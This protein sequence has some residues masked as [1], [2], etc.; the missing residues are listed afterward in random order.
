MPTYPLG[1]GSRIASPIDDQPII[2]TESQKE[3]R[4]KKSALDPKQN[5]QQPALNGENDERYDLVRAALEKAEEIYPS[6]D[7]E[8]Q[9]TE[10]ELKGAQANG[11]SHRAIDPIVPLGHKNGTYH[12]ISPSG[13]LRSMK[14]EGLEAGRGVKALF[15]G[16]SEEI[17]NWCQENFSGPNGDWSQKDA[18]H[19]IIKACNNRGIFDPAT[20][21]MRS[22]GVWRDDNTNAIAH[23]GD[24][25]VSAGG[26][27]IPLAEHNA[28]YIA[29]GATPINRPA[30]LA[31]SAVE[32]QEVF[33]QIR[34]SWGWKGLHDAD[35]F[36]G[37]LAAAALGG[38]PEWR[39][40]LYVHGSRGSGKSKLMELSATLLG[41]FAGDVV[42]DATEAG[43]RQSRNDQARPML[44][45]EF[46]PDDNA[47][48]GARQDGI[49]A[50]FRRMSGG[51]GGRISRGSADHSSVS[52]RTLGA[53]YV[54]SIN[55]IHLEPQDR[56]RFVM[57][58]LDS[59]PESSSPHASADALDALERR[60]GAISPMFLKRM[61]ASSSRWDKT[62]SAIAAEVR[63]LGFDARQAN[64]AATILA[65]RDLALFDG[66]IGPE[67]LSDLAPL[68]L[69]LLDE[70][71]DAASE[72]EGQEALNHLLGSKLQLDGGI[73]RTV[74]E[75]LGNV[76]ADQP[77]QGVIDPKGA[78]AREGIH[79]L[80]GS[81]QVALRTGK[82]GQ[83]ARL[84]AETKWR[85][86]AHVSALLKLDGA[87]RPENPV[88]VN[89]LEKQ[90]VILVSISCLGLFGDE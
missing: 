72:S 20:A 39:A 22:I 3:K 84:Y 26:D 19:W 80:L 5:L 78:L 60:A 76:V 43:L 90:R 34:N 62:H 32:M 9:G 35:I 58:Q 44:I 69:G 86:G 33:Q 31:A 79:V 75:L 85:N 4:T 27:V 11:K 42:N 7:G 87:T 2:E 67:R 74:G 53:A 59:L 14:A 63:K 47:R 65:G 15:T 36:L 77:I 71:A 17:E 82:T 6:G 28:K 57:L 40:H 50:L 48:N 12:F 66:D 21:D 88:R 73:K 52:F 83:L 81:E 8:F 89:N 10:A 30:V 16:M 29:I 25:V 55:H 56:S 41:D 24:V 54:T 23:C 51:G 13:E 37:W 70:T 46:E 49:L 38:Y 64:T 18:G 1:K 68:F 45:D 61:L